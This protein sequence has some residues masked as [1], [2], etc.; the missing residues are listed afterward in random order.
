MEI[1][2]LNLL[3]GPNIWSIEKKKL[4]A[5]KLDTQPFQNLNTAQ[6]PQLEHQL[7]NIL[8]SLFE[9][10]SFVKQFQQNM[11]IAELFMHIACELQTLAHMPCSFGLIQP[12]FEKNVFHVIFDYKIEPAGEYAAKTTC[13]A[14]EALLSEQQPFFSFKQDIKKLTEWFE[15]EKLEPSTFSLI[16]EAQKNGIPCTVEKKDSVVLLGYGAA[17]KKVC[18]TRSSRANYLNSNMVNT[19]QP[20]IDMLYPEPSQARIPL[21]AVTGTNGKTTVVRL[22]AHLARTAQFK[23]GFT[24]T[25]G[26]YINQHLVYTGDCSG[27]TSANTVLRDPSVNFAVLECARGGILRSGLGFDH[28]SVSIITNVTNDH[29]GQNDIHTLDDLARVKAVVAKSTLP[30]GYAILNADDPLVL[31]M[32][33]QLDCQIALFSYEENPSLLKHVNA[34]GLGAYVNEQQKIVIC[35]DCKKYPLVD[36]KDVPL[37]KN[38][39]ARCMIKNILPAILVGVIHSFSD[40]TILQ[41]LQTFYPCSAQLPGRMTTFNFPKGQVMI[42]YAH[43]EASFSELQHYL[44]QIDSRNKV[45]IIAGTGDRRDE[46]IERIGF[47]CAEIFDEIIIRHDIDTRGRCNNELTTLLRKGIEQSPLSPKVQV[48]SDEQEALAYAMQQA[49]PDTFIFYFAEDV[50]SAIEHMENLTG[51]IQPEGE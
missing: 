31:A 29:L 40:E 41:G 47:Y 44:S 24:T 35:R 5:V 51:G 7:K 48:I 6:S 2:K 43:N 23:V 8:P 50:L 16:Q 36:I 33:D 12:A 17:Q 34:G 21:V 25:E 26:I 4:I 28:C 42:D 13:H 39:M 10:Q 32:K 9:R 11:N 15:G 30:D 46:D 19:P 38:G 20:R 1:L 3:R 45:G 22:T 37:T 18:A 14:I 49:K 27:P